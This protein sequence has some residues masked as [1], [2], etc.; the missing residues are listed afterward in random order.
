MS[1]IDYA[2]ALHIFSEYVKTHIDDTNIIDKS[3]EA[4]YISKFHFYR[5]FKTI[6]GISVNRYIQELR[7]YMGM[8][9]LVSTN[10]KIVD[11]ALEH[12]FASHE[13]F[14][15]NFK[16]LYGMSPGAFRRLDRNNQ[17]DFINK[18]K[19]V[20]TLDFT[21]MELNLA[22]AAGSVTADDQYTQ[23]T[24][25]TFI[26]FTRRSNDQNV[27]SIPDF[28]YDCVN[29]L[30]AYEHNLRLVEEA[31]FRVC[32]DVVFEDEVP[33]F[34]EMVGVLVTDLSLDSN[35]LP[36]EMTWHTIENCQFITFR[37]VG[38]LFA[39][40]D[41]PI[42]NTYNMIYRYRLPALGISPTE[43]YYIE[44]YGSDFI[45]PYDKDAVATI[46]LSVE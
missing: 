31:I 46:M 30:E 2:S 7:L 8:L 12:G 33:S 23:L 41:T 25:A 18:N 6:T 44:R 37:H 34:T 1:Q 21:T 29:K 40:G 14:S 38:S 22:H 43:A 17:H 32:Y 45:S 10:Q 42:L 15:R 19:T 3:I 4:T 36:E 39:E 26:G 11:I 13:V 16:K 27:A 35:Q 20:A 28:V 24:N 5:F 9:A